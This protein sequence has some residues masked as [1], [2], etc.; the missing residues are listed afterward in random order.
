MPNN[1]KI[2]AFVPADAE[3]MIADWQRAIEHHRQHGNH[4]EVARLHRLVAQMQDILD[5]NAGLIWGKTQTI[6]VRLR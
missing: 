3:R 6:S 2:P 5:G 4:Q 1:R